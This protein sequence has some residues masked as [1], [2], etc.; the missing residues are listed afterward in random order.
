[1]ADNLYKCFSCANPHREGARFC[2]S[3][4]APLSGPAASAVTVPEHLVEKLRSAVTGERKRVTVLFAD[5]S[6]SM[7]LAESVDAEAWRTIMDRFFDLLCEGVHA[8]EGTVVQFTGDG[9]MA[10]FGAPIA[11]EDHAQRAARASLALTESVAE[12]A[13]QLRREQGLNFSARIG[14]NSGEVIVGA[15]GADLRV[16]YTAIGHTVGLAQR[17]ESLAE[18]GRVYMTEYTATLLEGFFVLS[19]LGRFDVKGARE[20]LGVSMLEGIGEARSRFDVSRARGLSGFVGRARELAVLESALERALAAEGGAIGIV[21][22]P[23]LGKSRL[24]HEFAELVRSRD[25]PVYRASAAAH[26]RNVP[27]HAALEH[28]RSFFSV[29]VEDDPRVVRE[30]V[31]GRLLLLDPSFADEL[32]LIFDFLGVPDPDRPVPAHGSR[33]TQATTARRCRAA[34]SRARRTRARRQRHRGPALDRRRQRR[35]PQ[36]A[37][38]VGARPPHARRRQL[39]ARVHG[40]VDATAVVSGATARSAR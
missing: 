6:G 34:G 39:P 1:M 26:A 38:R 5:V 30:R 18:P 25:I 14:L 24:S 8:Q 13:A 2:D 12:Y 28:L 10:L 22:E 17:M 35:V 40:A 20:P 21:G 3:C 4:G 16:D 27:F 9:I 11:H 29:S 23:G 33:G 37:D 31:A 7:D 36:D 15:I 32:P 19:D